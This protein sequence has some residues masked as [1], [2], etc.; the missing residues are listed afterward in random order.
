M[1]DR[2]STLELIRYHLFGEFSPV[3]SCATRSSSSASSARGNIISTP[4]LSLAP[5]RAFFRFQNLIPVNAVT[6]EDSDGDGATKGSV[7]FTVAATSL[8]DEEDATLG[9]GY[10]LK[11][12]SSPSV[13]PRLPLQLLDSKLICMAHHDLVRLFLC[14]AAKN[15]VVVQWRRYKATR[16]QWQCNGCTVAVQGSKK[17]SGC[18]MVAVQGSKKC[19]SCVMAVVQG[20]KNAVASSNDNAFWPP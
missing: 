10:C 16:M 11:L 18:V 20:S 13:A 12:P 14:K 1:I 9:V 5:H 7:S 3:K 4:A 15:A 19:S 2:V 17:C 8:D 6:S